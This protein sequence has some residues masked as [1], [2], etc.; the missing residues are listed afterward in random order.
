MLI[1]VPIGIFIKPITAKIIPT[2]LAHFFM[3]HI[4]YAT[5]SSATPITIAI[6]AKMPIF[7]ANIAPPIKSIASPTKTPSNPPTANN[8]KVK[9]VL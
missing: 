8:H 2:I 1:I 3:F 5:T 7:S 4:P 6:T 9:I